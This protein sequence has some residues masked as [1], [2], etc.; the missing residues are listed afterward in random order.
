MPRRV[1]ISE[2]SGVTLIEL[3]IV[4]VIIGVLATVAIP[5]VTRYIRKGKASEVYYVIQLF[6]QRQ[7]QFFSENGNYAGTSE[8]A[9]FP[10]TP[11]GPDSP[12]PLGSPPVLWKQLRVQPDRQN[13]YCSYVTVSG[14]AGDSTNIGPIASGEFN[15]PTAPADEDWYYVVAQC[16]F[17]GINTGVATNSVYFKASNRSKIEVRRELR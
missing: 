1:R 16:D 4:V 8:A 7:Q 10:A 17:D 9:F 12:Q 13:L 6:E 11:A 15:F 14:V 5:A 2:Q 3:M